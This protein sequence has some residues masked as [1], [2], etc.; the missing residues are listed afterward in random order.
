[1]AQTVTFTL[2]IADAYAVLGSLRKSSRHN[3]REAGRKLRA[4]VTSE[5]PLLCPVTFPSAEC[6]DFST[7]ADDIAGPP[8]VALAGHLIEVHAFNPE[9]ADYRAGVAVKKWG[10]G[11]L[12]PEAESFPQPSHDAGWGFHNKTD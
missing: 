8:Q 7:G 10:G 2:D 3:V 5:L 11:A 1:M 4:Q 6:G 12:A 9:L